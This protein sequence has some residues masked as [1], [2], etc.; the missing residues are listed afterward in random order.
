LAK[1]REICCS[2][3]GLLENY[4]VSIGHGTP[5]NIHHSNVYKCLVLCGA[6]S[7]FVV[8]AV[9]SLCTKNPVKFNETHEEN[10]KNNVIARWLLTVNYGLDYISLPVNSFVSKAT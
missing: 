6:A 3:T 7:E 9:L 4:E 10:I 5:A 2:K 1:I 8:I